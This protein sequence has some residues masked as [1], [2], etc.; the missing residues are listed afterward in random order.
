M[1]SRTIIYQPTHQHL[2]H[3]KID[4]IL[5]YIKILRL[6]SSAGMFIMIYIM[7]NF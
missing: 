1:K 7:E 4:A 2:L 3:E 5:F 6:F